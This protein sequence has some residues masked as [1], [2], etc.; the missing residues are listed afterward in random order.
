WWSYIGPPNKDVTEAYDIPLGRKPKDTDCFF[1]YG[2]WPNNTFYQ[3][4]FSE[5]LGT[6]IMIPAGPEHSI[7]RFGYY[8]AHDEVPQIAEAAIQ[9][10]SNDL[11]PADIELNSPVQSGLHSF[12]Y[13][14]GRYMIGADRSNESE[15]LVYHFHP[16]VYD[17]LS[18]QADEPAQVK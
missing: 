17:A 9:G 8:S 18:N 6:F 3:F 1:N 11:G 4:P 14:Q 16:L 7:L 2:L 15:H 12:R 10:M 13:N 5:M